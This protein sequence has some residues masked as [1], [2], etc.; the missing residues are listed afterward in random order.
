M[1]DSVGEDT[2]DDVAAASTPDIM[3][4]SVG[5]DSA[6]EDTAG[7]VAAAS[8]PSDTMENSVGED[9]VGEDTAGDVAA[10]STPSDVMADS[11]GEDSAGDVAA[12]STPSD[13][14]EDSVGEDSVGEVTA[15]E[16]TA[17]NDAAAASAVVEAKCKTNINRKI[18]PLEEIIVIYR[19]FG[20]RQSQSLATFRSHLKTHCFPSAHLSPLMPVTNAP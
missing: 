15:G 6:G 19:Y 5:E 8:T 9:S 11:E 2:A 14:M 3:T 17:C 4:D 18:K 1:A 13:T 20:V 7:D 12:A 16:D 10:A